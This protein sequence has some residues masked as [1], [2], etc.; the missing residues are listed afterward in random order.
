MSHCADTTSS[1]KWLCH[2][3]GRFG[4]KSTFVTGHWQKQTQPLKMLSMTLVCSFS[5]TLFGHCVCQ[6]NTI[7]RSNMW[8]VEQ[9]FWLPSKWKFIPRLTI[10]IGWLKVTEWNSFITAWSCHL[11]WPFGNGP[12]HMGEDINQ[13]SWC[14]D[15]WPS[16][17]AH[18]LI[19]AGRFSPMFAMICLLIKLTLHKWKTTGLIIKKNNF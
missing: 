14:P 8:W 6:V 2:Q 15:A 7:L 17:S 9:Y 4:H 11:L 1:F 19:P 10:K 13:G 5:L 12:S 18:W 3:N 16:P